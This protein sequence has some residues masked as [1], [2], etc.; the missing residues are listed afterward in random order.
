M[1]AIRKFVDEGGGFIGVG[2]PAAHQW[3]GKFFQLDDILGV[4]EENGFAL[5]TDRYNTT[6]HPDHFILADT[7]GDVDFGEGKISAVCRTA[8]RTAACCTVQ[9]CGRLLQR[10]SCTS[11]SPPTTMWKSTLM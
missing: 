1:T 8:L 6:A 2:E 5:N 10:R 3:Q 11:G 4:E 9:C 7:D